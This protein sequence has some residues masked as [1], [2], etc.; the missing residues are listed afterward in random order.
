MAN[1]IK[2]RDQDT[3]FILLLQ[4]SVFLSKGM[5]SHVI[6]NSATVKQANHIHQMLHKDFLV[7][8][9]KVRSQRIKKGK[10]KVILIATCFIITTIKK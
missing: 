9:N 7:N 1:Y 4:C 10:K 2:S 8:Q 5:F 3:L 6:M